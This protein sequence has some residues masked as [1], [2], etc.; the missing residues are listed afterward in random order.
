MK[1][2]KKYLLLI[3]F[4]AHKHEIH[5]NPTFFCGLIGLKNENAEK[6]LVLSTFLVPINT[7]YTRIQRFFVVW[8]GWKVKML[9]KCLFLNHFWCS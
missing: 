3:S 1:K 6:E 2:L 5:T 7:K 8:K 9:K 4:G